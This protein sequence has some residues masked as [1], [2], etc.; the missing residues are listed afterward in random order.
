MQN[1]VAREFAF[2]AEGEAPLGSH[3]SWQGAWSG[4]IT[5]LA[6][7]TILWALALAII[8]LAMHPTV[9]SLRGATIAAW[10]CLMATIIVATLVPE[11]LKT[12]EEVL[13]GGM[14]DPMPLTSD[15]STIP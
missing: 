13:G 12:H 1:V 8:P 2:R 5:T 9:G 15:L 3:V 4:T 14:I 11:T 7:A 6:A 10:I